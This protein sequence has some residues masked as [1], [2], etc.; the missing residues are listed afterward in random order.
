LRN[1]PWS[2]SE[3]ARRL[4]LAC[5]GG[6]ITA[7]SMFWL[8]WSAQKEIHWSVP[9]ASG[10]FYGLGSQL[11]FNALSN[12]LAD[13]YPSAPPA[14]LLL[15]V[16]LEAFLELYCPLLFLRCTASWEF[17]GRHLCLIFSA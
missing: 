13:A 17:H 16:A 9:C 2:M 3:E 5:I 1:R 15:Q 4:P 12:Y 6:P 8:G 11:I 14:L 10:F 7:V